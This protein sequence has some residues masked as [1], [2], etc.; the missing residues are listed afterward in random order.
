MKAVMTFGR[1][2]PPTSG[3]QLLLDK[4]LST[5]KKINAKPFLFVSHSQ[6]KKESFEFCRKDQIYF[7]GLS[8]NITI[9]CKG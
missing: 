3:H 8:K 4:L 9:Y 2:N 7:L 5:A 1:L 6:D